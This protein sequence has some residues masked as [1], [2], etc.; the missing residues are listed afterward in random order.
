MAAME[1]G[2]KTGNEVTEVALSE[3][4]TVNFAVRWV[5]TL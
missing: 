4:V 1:C 5:G 2:M 3:L